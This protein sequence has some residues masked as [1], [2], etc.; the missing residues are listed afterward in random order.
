MPVTTR[1]VNIGGRIHRGRERGVQKIPTLFIRDPKDMSRVLRDVTPG[2]E[3]V[4]QGEGV[5]TRKRDGTN[6]RI[7]V[8]GGKVEMVEKRRNP[9]REERAAGAEPGYV[10]AE[11]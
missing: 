3:W 4:L 9:S 7:T 8:R 1:W 10:Q 2:A 11:P 6:V 5:P